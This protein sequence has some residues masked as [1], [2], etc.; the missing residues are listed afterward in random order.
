MIRRP[1]GPLNLWLVESQQ[2]DHQQSSTSW[3]SLLYSSSA[4]SDDSVRAVLYFTAALER[5]R[6]VERLDATIILSL[7]P[8]LIATNPQR[9]LLVD[10]SCV[11]R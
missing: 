2:V 6:L 10:A 1:S 3:L 8:G 5:R 7:T 9:R 11:F 4:S